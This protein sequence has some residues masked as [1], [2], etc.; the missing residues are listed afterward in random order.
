VTGK[1]DIAVWISR[2]LTSHPCIRV[3]ERLGKGTEMTL[4]IECQGPDGR[5]LVVACTSVLV[6]GLISRQFAVVV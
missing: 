2:L 5:Q 3:V 4:I 1:P 6:E